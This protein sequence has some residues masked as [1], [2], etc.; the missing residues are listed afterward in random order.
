[1][2]DDNRFS[3]VDIAVNAGKNHHYVCRDIWILLDRCYGIK[4]TDIKDKSLNK[5]VHIVDG[6][7]VVWQNYNNRLCVKEIIVNKKLR[8]ALGYDKYAKNF[9]HIRENIAL[10]TIEQIKGVKL[11]RQYPVLGK[12]RI[13]GYDPVNNIAYEIDEEQHFTLR[14]IKSDRTREKDI[15]EVLGCEFV[16][17]CV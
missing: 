15:R 5:E 7:S 3:S 16:R 1:M 12:Y 9:A 10:K 11:I 14:N 4:R 8:D 2:C 17:I 6:I 13:D